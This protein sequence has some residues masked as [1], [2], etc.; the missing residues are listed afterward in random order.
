MPICANVCEIS[1]RA[2]AARAKAGSSSNKQSPSR[3]FEVLLIHYAP[4]RPPSI[5]LLLWPCSSLP[6]RSVTPHA[7]T[8]EN[9][10][11]KDEDFPG[12]LQFQGGHDQ[13]L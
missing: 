5:L 11:K 4:G 3:S 2:C 10:L 9:K 7:Q 6:S 1:T 8:G 13:S 12:G